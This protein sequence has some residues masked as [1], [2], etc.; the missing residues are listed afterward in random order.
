[1]FS[2]SVHLR[3]RTFEAESE[4]SFANLPQMFSASNVQ[5]GLKCTYIETD[6]VH[7]RQRTFEADS[8]ISFANL[9]QMYR[10]ASMYVHLR[11]ICTFEADS[12]I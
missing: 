12:Y 5:I 1:M 4:I 10:S 8:E 2:A 11:P 7:L 6:S 9:P 3:Q